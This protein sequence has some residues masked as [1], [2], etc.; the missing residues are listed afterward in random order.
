MNFEDQHFMR[1]F[2]GDRTPWQGLICIVCPK[3]QGTENLQF[4]FNDEIKI[5]QT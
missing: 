5:D 1:I 2:N 3:F 4:T